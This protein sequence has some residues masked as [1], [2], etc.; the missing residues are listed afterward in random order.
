[1]LADRYSVRYFKFERC[2][3]RVID[4]VNS[5]MMNTGQLTEACALGY[6]YML[7]SCHETTIGTSGNFYV[8]Q[9]EKYMKTHIYRTITIT[10][11][12]QALGI[13]DR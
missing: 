12:A 13:S 7:L 9:A 4:L 11:V 5:I 2:E 3:L 6:F 10:E 8:K 1:M